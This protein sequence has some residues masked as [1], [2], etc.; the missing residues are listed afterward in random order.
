MLNLQLSSLTYNSTGI[1]KS[2]KTAHSTRRTNKD[3]ERRTVFRRVT[4]DDRD[5]N[6]NATKQ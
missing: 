1:I 4:T 5:L 3:S 2:L 6:L